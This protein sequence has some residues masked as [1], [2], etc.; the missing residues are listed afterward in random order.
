MA[1]L[2]EL[3]IYRSAPFYQHFNATAVD[4]YLQAEAWLQ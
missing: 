4:T 2:Y 1:K 3:H